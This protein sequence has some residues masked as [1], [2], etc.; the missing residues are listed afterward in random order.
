MCGLIGW[1]SRNDAEVAPDLV[2][3][4][5]ER[6]YGR[7]QRGFGLI[8]VNKSQ[9]RVRR[10]T[11]PVKALLDVARSTAPT[12]LFHHRF[13]TSTDNEMEQTHPILVS[14]DE[15]AYDY[16]IMHNGVIRNSG[17]CRSEHEGLGY[18]YRT[19][20][21]YESLYR[22]GGTYQKFNDSEAFAIELARF[23]EHKSDG[24]KAYGAAAFLGIASD[25]KTKK[26]V[27]IFFGTNGD[28][29]LRIME[30]T[31]LLVASELPEDTSVPAM[32]NML[33]E[34]DCKKL[35]NSKNKSTIMDDI[36]S[37]PLTYVPEPE[38]VRTLLLPPK[39]QNL[40]FK[41]SKN[42][43]SEEK[44][45]ELEDTLPVREEAAQ[46]RLDRF[47]ENLIDD[48]LMPTFGSFFDN[49]AYEKMTEDDV[50]E[51]LMNIRDELIDQLPLLEN[52]REHFDDVDEASYNNTLADQRRFSDNEP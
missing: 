24:L 40:G 37:R 52:I 12:L 2:L 28:N 13:P 23:I 5:Y 32:P 33:Y 47:L 22:T 25:K 41:T 46:K 26:P 20:A 35:F 19:T 43:K 1:I 44:D 31:G 7:G 18:A 51:L 50:D 38:I 6:Q 42:S 45:F 36:F 11:E 3:D 29:P 21:E 9:V 39:T 48:V 17:E 15:L 4:Q 16:H 49:A 10:A 27:T 8:E 34:V 14:H 30:G